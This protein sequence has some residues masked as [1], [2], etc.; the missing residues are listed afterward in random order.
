[1]DSHNERVREGDSVVEPLALIFGWVEAELAK[2]APIDDGANDCLERCVA[3]S[4][5]PDQ[6]HVEIDWLRLSALL[7]E[8]VDSRLIF[9]I[10]VKRLFAH[11]VLLCGLVAIGMLTPSP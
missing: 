9:F 6:R 5:V 3:F 2:D 8:R 11:A 4:L 7:K 1:M 10:I